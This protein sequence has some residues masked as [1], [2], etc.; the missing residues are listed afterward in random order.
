M[1]GLQKVKVRKGNENKKQT[2]KKLNQTFLN[3]FMCLQI[4]KLIPCQFYSFFKD[5]E[6]LMSLITNFN[7]SQLYLDICMQIVVSRIYLFIYP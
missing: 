3:T 1:E 7:L 6:P 5:Q 2:N 4:E